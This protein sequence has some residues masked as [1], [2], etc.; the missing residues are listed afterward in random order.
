M[1]KQTVGSTI[2]A[3]DKCIIERREMI[4]KQISLEKESINECGRV[5]QYA[6]DVAVRGLTE[7]L[8]RI[9]DVDVFDA[10]GVVNDN[11]LSTLDNL[12]SVAGSLVDSIERHRKQLMWHRSALNMLEKIRHVL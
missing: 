1:K 7:R 2:A 8:K 12:E 5:I 3:W 10:A 9:D 6:T 4:E 11:V